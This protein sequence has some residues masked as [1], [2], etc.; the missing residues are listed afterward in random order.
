M[1]ALTIRKLDEQ[2]K[3]RLRVRAAH[4][5]RSMEEEAR[6]ILRS[7]L[8]VPQASQQNLAECIRRRFVDLGGVEL[9]PPKRDRLRPHPKFVP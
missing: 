2:T 8:A 6:E 1:A 5:G 7:T 4:H 3:A 9:K